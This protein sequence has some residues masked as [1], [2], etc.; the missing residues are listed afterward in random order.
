[1]VFRSQSI[2]SVFLL[3]LN[4]LFPDFV[5]EIVTIDNPKMGGKREQ[6]H[7]GRD[8]RDPATSGGRQSRQVAADLCRPS[9]KS[10]WGAVCRRHESAADHCCRQP[11]PHRSE[12]CTTLLG[13]SLMSH[14]A[15]MKQ[16]FPFSN[17]GGRSD[18]VFDWPARQARIH[19][20]L[21]VDTS[22]SV[23][24]VSGSREPASRSSPAIQRNESRCSNAQQ[25]LND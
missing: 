9:R 13:V 23:A 24:T 21:V 17:S 5:H 1:M 14:V 3:S 19:Q 2:R 12:V 7:S 8:V 20:V 18:K 22:T 10:G 16:C 11:C 25:Q 4:L 6:Q 15:P